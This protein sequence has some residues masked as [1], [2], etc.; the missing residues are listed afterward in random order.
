MFSFFCGLRR[1]FPLYYSRVSPFR[2]TTST[3]TRLSTKRSVQ[4]LPK[5]V[6][7]VVQFQGN[8]TFY[9]KNLLMSDRSLLDQIGL[10]S[11]PVPVLVLLGVFRTISEIE[12]SL[13]LPA[14][15]Y[16][17]LNHR[18]RSKCIHIPKPRH[19]NLPLPGCH[20][21]PRVLK[22]VDPLLFA[23]VHD[24]DGVPSHTPPN[25]PNQNS[26]SKNVIPEKG[27]EGEN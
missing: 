27:G 4:F 21:L 17:T 5:Y 15:S 16:S 7:H 11:S 24:T 13:L 26:W 23:G 3:A 18:T 9:V 1:S 12:H 25:R 14:T 22:R 2:N 6:S 19:L 8:R 10:G 20:T